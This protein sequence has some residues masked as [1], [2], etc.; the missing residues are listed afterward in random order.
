MVLSSSSSRGIGNRTEDTAHDPMTVTKACL[1]S[2]ASASRHQLPIDE[3]SEQRERASPSPTIINVADGRGTRDAG[4]SACSLS[5]SCQRV[6]MIRFP[7]VIS[8]VSSRTQESRSVKVTTWV[9]E[10]RRWRWWRWRQRHRKGKAP[11]SCLS[12]KSR[13]Q[14]SSEGKRQSE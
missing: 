5:L 10:P 6:I 2:T 8:F 14:S 13:S 3:T 7:C 12:S 1:G 11:L 9:R 4:N